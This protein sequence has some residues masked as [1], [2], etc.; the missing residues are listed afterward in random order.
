LPR[1]CIKTRKAQEGRGFAGSCLDECH[2]LFWLLNRP[3]T[4]F[5]APSCRGKPKEIRGMPC[6]FLATCA[7]AL[8]AGSL[9]MSQIGLDKSPCIFLAIGAV[10]HS[11]GS[12]ITSQKT[13]GKCPNNLGNLPEQSWQLARS[14]TAR[15]VSQRAKRH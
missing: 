13:L 12:L 2:T 9:M 4:A 15:A 14:R 10:A 8:C 11:A 7:V 5:R 3:A 1:K 6:I